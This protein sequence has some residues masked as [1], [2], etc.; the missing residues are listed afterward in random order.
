MQIQKN[1]SQHIQYINEEILVIPV[2]LLFSQVNMWQGINTQDFDSIIQ[3]IQNYVVSMPRAHAETNF[4]YKQIIP[5]ILFMFDNKLF[6][7]QRKNNASEQRLASKF[8]LGIGVHIRQDDIEHNDIFAW[9]LR[10]FHEEVDYQG[11]LSYKKIGILNDDS[12][13]VGKVHLGIIWLV[14]GNSDKI[15]IKNEHKSGVLLTFEECMNLYE[16]MENWS[17]ICFDFLQTNLEL[18]K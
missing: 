7:M 10:E 17:R 8:S 3:S 16:N 1:Q 15:A 18:M 11:N 9:A 4:A 13:D 6:V 2:K 12:S 5:Y 14:I